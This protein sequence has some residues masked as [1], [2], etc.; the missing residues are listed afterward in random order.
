MLEQRAECPFSRQGPGV[1][2]ADYFYPPAPADLPGRQV[3]WRSLAEV[4][5]ETIDHA[6]NAGV[7]FLIESMVEQDS[8]TFPTIES[9]VEFVEHIGSPSL[10]LLYD[11]YHFQFDGVDPLKVL[12]DHVDIVGHVHLSDSA[13]G[14]ERFRPFP[15]G[16]DV[17]FKPIVAFLD[18]KCPV[19][20]WAF[21][22]IPVTEAAMQKSVAY[23]SGLRE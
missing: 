1:I 6:E 8:S 12:T 7:S 2:L 23:I 19:P 3:R 4:V 22:G 20:F 18:R 21:E 5:R 15:G 10:R 9:C 14:K 16:G 11:T 17:D 13:R